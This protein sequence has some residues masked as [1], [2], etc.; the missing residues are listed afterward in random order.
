[1]RAA[2]RSAR[3]SIPKLQATARETL[4]DGLIRFDQARG[5]RGPVTTIDVSGDWGAALGEV[6]GARR[7]AGMAARRRAQR[8]GQPGVDRPPAR[9]QRRRAAL[10]RARD[11]HAAARP[12]EM[13]GGRAASLRCSARR[14]R[15]CRRR[16][17]TSRARG[18]FASRPRSRARMVAMDP[19]TGRVLAM[20][21]GFS[22][23]ESEFNRATPGL[24]PAGLFVQAV[25]LL[26]G[27]RQR[28]HAV[29]GGPRRADRDP[30][31]RRDLAA[32]ELRRRVLR[33]V[34]AA[35]RH[36]ALAQRH[37]GAP[38]AGHGHAARRRIRQALR[39]LRR[40]RCRICRCRSAPAR[41]RCCAW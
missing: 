33:P 1:M 3:R 40:S 41:R 18:S 11:R 22:F 39:H 12:D 20:V 38:G 16:S 8:R 2:S 37:D 13:G 21:G 29:L 35:D 5:F 30:L 36:R 25:R 10:R 31:R 34:D 4:Q 7:R 14:R 19:H 15:L 27:A 32:G 6:P 28:L 17:P 26:G 23:A 9:A 24:A